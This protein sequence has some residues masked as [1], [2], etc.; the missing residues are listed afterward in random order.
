MTHEGKN[1]FMVSMTLQPEFDTAKTLQD[2]VKRY[3]IK[4]G[5]YNDDPKID[6]NLANH[7]GMVRIGCEASNSWYMTLA[8]EIMWVAMA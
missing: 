7:T 2:H 3:G 4:L 5:F 6:S 8:L 1:V